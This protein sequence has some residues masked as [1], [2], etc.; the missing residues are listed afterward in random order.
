[1]QKEPC[2]TNVSFGIVEGG[3]EFAFIDYPLGEECPK[4]AQP[5]YEIAFS[6]KELDEF[7]AILKKS[8]RR[9]FWQRIK[10]ALK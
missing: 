3:V 2:Q 6:D 5:T 7:L 8:R 1:M 9:S 4:D 10:A